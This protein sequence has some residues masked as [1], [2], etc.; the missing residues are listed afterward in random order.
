[1]VEH[2]YRRGL[3]LSCRGPLWSPLTGSRLDPSEHSKRGA[4]SAVCPEEEASG[5]LAGLRKVLWQK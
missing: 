5:S 3:T 4:E 1:M 2:V